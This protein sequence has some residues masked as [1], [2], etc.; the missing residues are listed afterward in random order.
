MYANREEKRIRITRQFRNEII[1][2]VVNREMNT[3]TLDN[4]KNYT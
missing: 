2:E 1:I 4:L 3:D